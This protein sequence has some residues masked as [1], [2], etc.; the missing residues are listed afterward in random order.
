MAQ[1]PSS[2]QP[3]ISP[4]FQ[5]ICIAMWPFITLMSSALKLHKRETGGITWCSRKG[6]NSPSSSSP[7]E[8]RHYNC[9]SKTLIPEALQGF[10][11]K[12]FKTMTTSSPTGIATAEM[13]AL[14]FRNFNCLGWSFPLLP[15][16]FLLWLDCFLGFL[17]LFFRKHLHVFATVVIES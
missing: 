4:G 14:L 13:T 6:K 17:F 2:S 3:R 7:R 8:T 16:T 5:I 10:S 9:F 12:G 11:S 15:V 1:P